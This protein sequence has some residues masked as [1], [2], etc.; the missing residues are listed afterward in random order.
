MKYRVKILAGYGFGTHGDED[1]MV[2]TFYYPYTSGIIDAKIIK[3]EY[4]GAWGYLNN[5]QHQYENEI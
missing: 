2:R 4:G 1:I 5:L 3:R